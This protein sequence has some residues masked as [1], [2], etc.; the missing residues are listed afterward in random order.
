VRNDTSSR[1][2]S[3]PAKRLHQLL[4]QP[5][6]SPSQPTAAA[7]AV[8]PPLPSSSDALHDS[9]KGSEK[10]GELGAA[11]DHDAEDAE[12]SRGEGLWRAKI[13]EGAI[14]LAY[15]GAASEPVHIHKRRQLG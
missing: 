6:Q 2:A 3:T 10:I 13:E 7:A 1:S 8:A 14:K 15:A 12:E 9:S 5:S 4:L 11:Q